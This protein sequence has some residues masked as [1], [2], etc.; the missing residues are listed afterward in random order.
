MTS[1]C[2]H[3]RPARIG[4]RSRARRPASVVRSPAADRGA[5]LNSVQNA[6]ELVAVAG[7]RH[8]L[9]ACD[10]AALDKAAERI[11]ERDRSLLARDRHLLM[12]VLQRVLANVLA[13]PVA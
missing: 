13:C 2:D 1:C 5:T 9:G 11:F 10:L 6:F 4:T 7:A 8:R 12:Q 3:C